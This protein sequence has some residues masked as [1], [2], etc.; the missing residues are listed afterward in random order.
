[1][2]LPL[3]VTFLFG[4][5]D[6]L[7]HRT[8]GNSTGRTETANPCIDQVWTCPEQWTAGA[9]QLADAPDAK[10]FIAVNNIY[11]CMHDVQAVQWDPDVHAGATAWA[12]QTGVNMQH[13][14]G[15]TPFR[16]FSD[17]ENLASTFAFS[18]K[19]GVEST[20]MWYAEIEK[21]CGF[22]QSCFQS[23]EAGHFTAMIWKSVNKI[24]YADTT[25][26]IAVGRY[27]GCD[28]QPPNLN[29][30][31]AA[32]VPP[33]KRDWATCADLVLK[34]CPTFMDLKEEHV[35]GCDSSGACC[36]GTANGGWYVTYGSKCSAKYAGMKSKV[37][38]A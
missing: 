22:K 36:K 10:A 20:H 38:S 25:G 3:L 17:G 16:K 14:Q 33:P 30:A 27:R 7:I 4:L 31:Y 28:G 19:P 35:E 26:K 2:Q 34:K 29:D 1:M 37:T 15:G 24:A 13:S 18:T 9:D 11:R 5:S 12:T 21:P 6:A 32:M 23:F 8:L